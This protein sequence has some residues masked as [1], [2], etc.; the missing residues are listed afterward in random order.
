MPGDGAGSIGFGFQRERK[1]K[2]GGLSGGCLILPP[3]EQ[4]LDNER[5]QGQIEDARDHGEPRFP[6]IF[7]LVLV[8][9]MLM[10]I[11]GTRTRMTT[12]RMVKLDFQARRQITATVFFDTAWY[13]TRAISAI[14]ICGNFWNRIEE[15]E[16]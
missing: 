4:P 15:R 14:A 16:I 2:S 7:V 5:Q 6:L 9:E 8:L 3:F 1:R 10:K 12:R 13:Q 11:R